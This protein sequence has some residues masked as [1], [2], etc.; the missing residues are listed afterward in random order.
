MLCDR[1]AGRIFIVLLMNSSDTNIG[2][3]RL[4]DDPRNLVE[5]EIKEILVHERLILSNKLF[6]CNLSSLGCIGFG[7]EI[8]KLRL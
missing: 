2:Y 4:G 5:N 1:R 7:T 8:C 3:V 6:P